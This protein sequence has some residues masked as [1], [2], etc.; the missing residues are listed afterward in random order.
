MW[1]KKIMA[2]KVKVK[3][4]IPAFC[5][6]EGVRCSIAMTMNLYSFIVRNGVM[7]APDKAPIIITKQM[8]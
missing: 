5:G 6:R 2:H 4:E 1:K 7:V 3:V 8:P